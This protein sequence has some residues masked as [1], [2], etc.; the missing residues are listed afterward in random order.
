MK[1]TLVLVVAAVLSASI[2]FAVVRCSARCAAAAP[3]PS[4]ASADEIARLAR[5]LGESEARQA[6]LQ[7]SLEDLRAEIAL[8]SSRDSRVPTGEIEQAVARALEKQAGS[9]ETTGAD[10][11]HAAGRFDA[12][13]AFEDLLAPNLSR[14][15]KLAKWKAIAAA[16]GLDDVVAMFEEYAKENSGSASAQVEL[17]GAYLQKVFKAGNGPEAGVWATK[18]DKAFDAAL[19]IDDHSWDARFS[20]A[21]S[22]SFW[23]PVFGKQTEA[24]RNFEVLLDQQADQPSDPKFAQSWLFLGNL[25]Q[26][27]G[28][29]DQAVA[30]WQKGLASFPDNAALQQQIANAQ[31]H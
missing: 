25:Y 8:Q 24:I 18:A 9:P 28:K 14:D 6:S 16:G 13:A 11:A 10:P 19:A 12:R 1:P 23:P 26:Q 17:G 2:S 30:T 29:M 31:G 22:L 27:L 15:A 21:V 5:A 20:K 4:A 3:S 7:K